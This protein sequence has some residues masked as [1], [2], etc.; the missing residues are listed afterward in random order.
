MKIILLTLLCSISISAFCQLSSVRNDLVDVPSALTI[1]P[2]GIT[3]SD[4]SSLPTNTF[5]GFQGLPP[6]S[7]GACNTGVGY[8]S[9]FQNTTGNNNTALGYNTLHNNETG[10]YLTAIGANSLLNNTGSYNTAVGE[11][12]LHDNTSGTYNSGLGTGSL[13]NCENGF[14]NTATGAYSMYYCESCSNNTSSGYG[15]IEK[16][17]SGSNNIGIGSLCGQTLTSGDKITLIG[18]G[19]DVSGPGLMNSSAFGYGAMITGS[20]QIILGDANITSIGGYANFANV[21]DR[22]MKENI[23]YNRSLGLDFILA[24]K[25]VKYTY[26]ADHSKRERDGLIAQD[27]Q[28]LLAGKNISFSGLIVD[29]NAEQTL[30]LSYDNFVIPL[31]NAVQEQQEMIH[32]LKKQISTISQEMASLSERL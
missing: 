25:T 26:K 8:G 9:F 24:L 13:F 3:S 31:I 2:D 10:F 28:S 21:S 20:N 19:A 7:T 11:S 23:V 32:E 12:A 15:A 1:S 6:N 30:R 4:L 16:L 29:E 22:R 18:A 14:S 17:I 27:V 5:L